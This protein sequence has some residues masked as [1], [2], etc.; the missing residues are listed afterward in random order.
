MTVPMVIP[1]LFREVFERT[2]AVPDGEAPVDRQRFMDIGARLTVFY[3]VDPGHYET[4]LVT[5]A[6]EFFNDE[7]TQAYYL[8]RADA[9]GL[10]FTDAGLMATWAAHA[11]LR[12]TA[13]INCNREGSEARPP[14]SGRCDC[15]L[16]EGGG[17][18]TLTPRPSKKQNKPCAIPPAVQLSFWLSAS[19]Q[20]PP[21]KTRCPQT[22]LTCAPPIASP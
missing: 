16:S 15:N 22:I 19:W 14:S 5:V 1:R 4:A 7:G 11:D 8:A 18:G 10:L 3:G 6:T 17:L 21:R 9:L 2:G 13:A 12:Q 20:A